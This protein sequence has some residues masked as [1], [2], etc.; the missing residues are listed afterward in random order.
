MDVLFVHSWLL[1]VQTVKVSR[2]GIEP[3]T[4]GYL[5]TVCTDVYSPPLY[6]LSYRE[7]CCAKE[8]PLIP[9]PQ[10]TTTHPIQCLLGVQFGQVYYP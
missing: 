9:I 3:V 4:D 5:C 10:R 2:T 7:I 1:H 6:Q 8:A